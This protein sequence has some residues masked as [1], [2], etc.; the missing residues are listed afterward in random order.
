[1]DTAKSAV[2]LGKPI[3]LA[4]KLKYLAWVWF[5]SLCPFLELTLVSLEGS[6]F[7]TN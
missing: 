5:L 2:E 3:L 1:M 7:Q 6:H 4:P